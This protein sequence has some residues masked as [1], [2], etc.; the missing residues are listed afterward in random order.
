MTQKGKAHIHS[1]AAL[2]SDVSDGTETARTEHNLEV[3]NEGILVDAPE[4]V[5]SRD[6]V[7]DLESGIR[8][9][10]WIRMCS[11]APYS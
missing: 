4:D 8:E 9:L 1:I 6:V 3:V 5:T 10:S 11:G 7:A 2:L